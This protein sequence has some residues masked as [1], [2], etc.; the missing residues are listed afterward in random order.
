MG[1]SRM[2]A[3]DITLGALFVALMA[4]GA[5]ITAFLPFLQVLGVPLTLQTFIAVLAGLI[6]GSR[7]G[8][9]SILVYAVLG[10]IGAPIFAGFGGGL[11]TVF[12]PTF[13]FIISYFILAYFAGKVAE[14]NRRLPV[15]I[16]GALVGIA[17]NY[18]IGVNW[19]YGAMNFWVEGDPVSYV[20]SWTSMVPFLI[21]DIVLAVFGGLFAYRME[22]S[23][24]YKTP[25]RQSA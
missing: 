15:Y 23:F 25:L 1:K 24:L 2:T 7:L 8:F 3:Y 10:L 12:S 9:F 20:V 22:K 4:V 17:V 19:F 18:L 11:S 14:T 21:K 6:L 16:A 5:N 13:G